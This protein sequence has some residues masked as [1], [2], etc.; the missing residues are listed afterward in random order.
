MLRPLRTLLHNSPIAR[1]VLIFLLSFLV[2]LMIW[3]QVKDAYGHAITF[4]ASKLVA[5]LKNVRLEELVQGHD[6]IQATFSPSNKRSNILIDVPVKTSAYTFNAP[7]TFA[8]M[9]A[10]YPFIRRRWRG[11]AE[12]FVLLFSIHLLYVFSGEANQLTEVFVSRGMEAPSVAKIFAYQFLWGF[13]DNLV[14]RF[15][16]FLIGFYMYVR[17][18][19]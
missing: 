10:L 13:T 5:G 16:P 4:V 18:R 6:T 15:E 19:K 8:I 12:A 1:T 3:L 2:S 9:S 14:I 7:L 11:Y 17:F